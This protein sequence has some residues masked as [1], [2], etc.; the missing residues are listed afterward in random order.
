ME[1]NIYKKRRDALFKQLPKD[2]VAIIPSLSDNPENQPYDASF[3][4]L[5]GLMLNNAIL[6]MTKEKSVEKETIYR[7]KIDPVLSLWVCS[8]P[9]DDELRAKSAIKDLKDFTPDALLDT[10]Y[11]EATKG[12]KDFYFHYAPKKPNLPPSLS[13]ALVKKIRKYLPH[14]NLIWLSPIISEL[15]RVKTPQEV[16]LFKEAIR[17][18]K[19][20]IINVFSKRS[21]Y[22]NECQ[23]YADYS[24]SLINELNRKSGFNVIVAAGKNATIL[25]YDNN[26][27]P[28]H[29]NSMILIDAGCDYEGYN[30]D[31]TRCFP[32][33]RLFPAKAKHI[34][35]AVLT[36]QELI[37]K[38]IKPGVSLQEIN[39]NAKDII[40][41]VYKDARIVKSLDE[42]N[43][44]YYH[45][46]SHYLGLEVH[47]VGIRSRLLKPGCVLTVEPGCYVEKLGIGIRIEDDVLVTSSG[48]ENLSYSIPKKIKEIEAL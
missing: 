35:E 8:P 20:A 48:Y 27:S 5:T 34:Y 33:G 39:D 28:I 21:T 25:H 6:V 41:R 40:F 18:T 10:L 45:G 38:S 31:I 11:N 30:S 46:A 26:N 44:V 12:M 3:Y 17:I 7:M 32:R 13:Q 2:S 23:V 43:K 24:A 16:A 1:R 19:N 47:D 37:I 14:I 29:N 15:R 22:Q 9:P 4:Y 42:L 36:A